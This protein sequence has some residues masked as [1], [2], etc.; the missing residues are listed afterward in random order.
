MTGEEL[1]RFEESKKE[2]E[3]QWQEIL[4]SRRETD[5]L[6]TSLNRQFG[7]LG[8]KL[9]DHAESLIRPSLERAMREQ[10]EMT[11][12]TSPQRIRR[13]GETLEI[14][15]VAH[16]GDEIDDVYLAEI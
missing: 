6:I 4:A 2:S 3:R 13:N 5:C 1:K 8:N 9:G 14:D 10:F 12:I 16:A 7:R 15:F 11:V